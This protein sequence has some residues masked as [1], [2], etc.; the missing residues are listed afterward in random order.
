MNAWRIGYGIGRTLFQ[1]DG[2]YYTWKSEHPL[3]ERI[4]E[5]TEAYRDENGDF[6]PPE[7]VAW[8]GGSTGLIDARP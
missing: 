5:L 2:R 8:D 7:C 4:I 6:I 3:E 1:I